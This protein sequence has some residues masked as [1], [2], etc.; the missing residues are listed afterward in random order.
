[1][2]RRIIFFTLLCLS[3]TTSALAQTEASVE[4]MANVASGDHNPLWLNANRYG[5]SSLDKTNG[6]LRGN[7][8]RSM[9]A[10]SARRWAWAAGLDMAVATG[11]TSTVVVHQAYGELRWM[12]GLLTIG[13]KEQRAELKNQELSTGS[14]T[15]GVNARPV[16]SVRL[17]LPDYWTIPYTRGWAAIKGHLAYGITTD[18][19][20]QEGFV[21]DQNRYTKNTML[22]TKAGYLR[23]GREDK[24][25]TVEL[26]LEMA[27]Q[28]G[29]TSYNVKDDLDYLLPEVDNTGG[30]KGAL[31][32]FVPSGAEAIE[33]G[34]DHENTNGN[35]LGSWL[36]RVNY[37]KP[38]WGVSLYADHFFEDQ[39]SM[40]F[41][42]YDGYGTGENYNKKEDHRW[43]LYD[44]RDMLIGM[45]L[46]LKDC[47]WVNTVVGEYVYTKYQSG[48]VYHDHSPSLSDHICGRDDYY[49]HIV[50]TG[51][52]H[53]GQVMGNPLFL[54][55][56]YNDDHQLTVKDNRFWAWHLAV[57]GE[58]AEGLKYRLMATWQKGFGRYDE[59]YADPRENVSIMAE[60]A[61]SFPNASKLKNWYAKAAVGMDFGK[62]LGDNKG[63][64][65]T[66]G[67]RLKIENRK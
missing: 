37:D 61:Y 23:L 22:H 47:R 28:Y 25:L 17:S 51:W 36:M 45:E 41:L 21:S 49:N 19:R 52:Q 46:R 24:P 6:Y 60:A 3:T 30:I 35:H 4:A 40:F 14:Q 56:L 55:P 54:S 2:Y 63:L 16:P 53:W 29:G 58:P 59:L 38:Q 33:E 64:Q 12:K 66:V 26:G 7:I 44:L 50:F 9:D 42:D 1:M 57:A 11:F 32:A 8:A 43:F 27:C 62:L 48:A 65:L 20:W 34:S 5:L 67:R 39:S 18:G 15:L 10:D 31:R 13:S